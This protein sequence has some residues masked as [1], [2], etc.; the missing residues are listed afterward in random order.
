MTQSESKTSFNIGTGKFGHECKDCGKTILELKEKFPEGTPIPITCDQCKYK[1]NE[2][3]RAKVYRDRFTEFLKDTPACYHP[4]IKFKFSEE[5]RKKAKT[6]FKDPEKWGVM[7]YGNTGSGKTTMALKLLCKAF[8]FLG[9]RG[10]FIESPRLAKRLRSDSMNG[11]K[12][13]EQFK[14]F[15]GVK[16]LVIDDFLTEQDDHKDK[17]L[18]ESLISERE[19][20]FMKTIFTTN[21]TPEDITNQENGYTIRMKSRLEKIDKIAIKGE[22]LRKLKLS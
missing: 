11:K 13:E 17:G 9:I 19:K 3:I 7:F 14:Y 1:N 2:H 22:D 8:V 5:N 16:F 12:P 4:Y 20:N 21:S 10:E 18:I 15:S 6:F